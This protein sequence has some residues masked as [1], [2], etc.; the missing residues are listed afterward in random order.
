M[1]KSAELKSLI[2]CESVS[3]KSTSGGG[4]QAPQAP[5]NTHRLL[6]ITRTYR[7]EET[8]VEYTKVEVVRKA[9]IIDAYVKIRTTRDD[10]FIRT[11]FALDET[12]KDKLRKERRRLQE[13]L[14]RVKRNEAKQHG[15]GAGRGAAA[16]AAAAASGEVKLDANGQPIPPKAHIYY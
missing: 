6:K 12:E 14:R 10:E 16:A 13:Q 15:K 4:D 8:G 11:A 1:D 5:P 7:D 2:M 9:M 3:G